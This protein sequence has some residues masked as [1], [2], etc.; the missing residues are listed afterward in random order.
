MRRFNFFQLSTIGLTFSHLVTSIYWIKRKAWL[1]FEANNSNISCYPFFKQCHILSFNEVAYFKILFYSYFVIS[2]FLIL[3][4]LTSNKKR[5]VYFLFWTLFLFKLF[6]ICSRYN[7]MGNYHL[8]HLALCATM[9]INLQSSWIYRLMLCLQYFFA[10]LL[11][12]NL[13]WSSGAALVNRSYLIPSNELYL[14]SLSYLILFELILIW[15]LC[16]QKTYIKYL[17]FFQLFIIHT[18]SI[19]IVGFYYPLIMIG[20]ILPIFIFD[21]NSRKHCDKL[22]PSFLAY[23]LPFIFILWNL[24]PKIASTDPAKDGE[25]RYF[26]LS[27]LDARV[28][29]Q[30]KTLKISSDGSVTSLLPPRISNAIRVKCDPLTYNNYLQRLCKKQNGDTYLF[31]VES[32]RTTE[33]NFTNMRT[34]YDVCEEI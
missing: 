8:M 29:C 10:G 21:I 9:V 3:R 5:W 18:Y 26:S 12:I 27:M 24:F 6:F 22:K 34:Y 4:L 33:T 13:E 15:G 31:H 23:S 7:L 28:Q 1:L 25:I 16:S 2:L 30:I 17:T 20:L 14:Y 32:R 11:K 19:S